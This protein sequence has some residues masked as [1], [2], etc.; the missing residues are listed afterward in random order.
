MFDIKAN[1]ET[2]CLVLKLKGHMSDEEVGEAVE[3]TM[4]ETEKLEPGFTIIND[5]SDLNP[6]S[7]ASSEKIK[8]AQIYVFGKGVKKV[9]RVISNI[10]SQMQFTRTQD[11]AGVKYEVAEVSNMSEALIL[12]DSQ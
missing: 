3:K 2:N 8:E 9:I 5:I 1:L 12:A 10:V 7:M 4:S 11:E 6:A